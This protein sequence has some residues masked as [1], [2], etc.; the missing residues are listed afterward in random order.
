MQ[1]LDL[2]ESVLFDRPLVSIHGTSTT[3][4]R[5]VVHDITA[6]DN[7]WTL[8]ELPLDTAFVAIDD[9]QHTFIDK[10]HLASNAVDL[11][12][13]DGSTRPVWL[14]SISDGVLMP[15]TDRT[16]HHVAVAGHDP[17]AT[18]GPTGVGILTHGGSIRQATLVG[19]DAALWSVE[20]N[21]PP[22]ELTDSIVWDVDQLYLDLDW[23]LLTGAEPSSY[24][25]S[26]S[27]HPDCTD[28]DASDPLF[29]RYHPLLDSS[30]WDLRI[31]RE[32]PY[33]RFNLPSSSQDLTCGFEVA[34]APEEAVDAQL[35]AFG[36]HGIAPVDLAG[37]DGQVPLG[38]LYADPF[39]YND[40]DEDGMYDSW[41]AVFRALDP[42][43]NPDGDG[44]HNLEEFEGGTLPND[45]DTDDD[46][47]LDGLDTEA[48][49]PTL[50]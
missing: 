15:A 9:F 24:Q 40:C 42:L 18:G 8:E 6:I 47:V 46:L 7:S 33:Y 32:S 43:A 19:L 12:A 25:D 49:D 17:Y 21:G 44:A 22:P 36:N 16:L 3:G 34:T 39:A 30:L 2:R 35:G 37:A 14:R 11:S 41:E 45:D 28:C 50:P 20:R 38:D 23:G 31:F 5:A 26:A 27:N 4:G 48:L 1:R 10:V 29:L 13:A